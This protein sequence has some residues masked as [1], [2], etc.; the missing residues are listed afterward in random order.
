M[1]DAL[2]EFMQRWPGEQA[3]A[4]RA[5]QPVATRRVL[6]G[7]APGW[8][9]AGESAAAF[10][11]WNGPW[12]S[13]R[14]GFAA[15]R[16]DRT[17]NDFFPGAHAPNS[18]HARD[19]AL[20]RE[21]ARYLVDSNPHAYAAIDSYLANVIETGIVPRPMVTDK[22]QRRAFTETWNR[23]GGLTAICDSEADP[24]G[25]ATI[26]DLMTIWLAELFTAGGCLMHRV[27]LP[28]TGQRQIP[29]AIELLP[30][31]RFAD[32]ADILTGANR[33]TRTVIRGVEIDPATRRAIRYW[34]RKA[35]PNDLAAYDPE[36]LPLPAE[37][38]HYGY[39]QTRAGQIRGFTHLKAAVLYLWRLGLY[40]DNEMLASTMKSSWA[41]KITSKD[42]SEDLPWESD[43]APTDA[44]GQPIQWHEG[45]QV[46]QA[47]PG[48]DINAIG[49]NI[50][51]DTQDWLTHIERAIAM[52]VG[53]S[54]MAL[55]RDASEANLSAARYASSEDRRRYRRLQRSTIDHFC[56]PAYRWMT[57]GAVRVGLPAYPSPQQF[58]AAPDEYLRVNLRAPGWTSV[59]P[60]QDAQAKQIEVLLGIASRAN[61]ISQGAGVGDVEETFEQLGN[62]E[63]DGARLNIPIHGA[64]PQA[65]EPDADDA[66]TKK[67]S[68]RPAGGG[69]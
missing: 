17:V 12:G 59:N 55:T 62:E 43:D 56:H 57:E 24:A 41:Y 9:R 28:L 66:P 30:E 48:E 52:A 7:R 34:V 50:P 61:L 19:A 4:E 14:G 31:E 29:V 45:G 69:R 53:Q 13:T 21:R 8:M 38:C 5:R 20:M 68:R 1:T 58:L 47:R 3:L 26:Y 65:T 16:R 44:Y 23:W 39:I 46:F 10:N 22:G 67:S 11:E 36:P 63:Q 15:A 32:D 18:L 25:S 33:K 6:S 40:T 64:P 54:R 2:R 60:L 27:E 51:Q 49:P 35:D 37:D 42:D